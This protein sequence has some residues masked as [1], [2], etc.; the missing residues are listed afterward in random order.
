MNVYAA[1]TDTDNVEILVYKS[2]PY[3]KQLPQEFF[4]IWKQM[5]CHIMLKRK[6]IEITKF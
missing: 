5:Q 1:N 3:K 2:P 6:N 4:E